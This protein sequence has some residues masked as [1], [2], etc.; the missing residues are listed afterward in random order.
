MPVCTT[1]YQA[2]ATQAEVDARP[3]S[4]FEHYTDTATTHTDGTWDNLAVDTLA[5]GQLA[6]NGDQ[7]T[8]LYAGSGVESLTATRN[9]RF[10]IGGA[11]FVS[12]GSVTYANGGSWQVEYG[13]IRVSASVIRI[14]AR[15]YTRDG[16]DLTA[17][18]LDSE[19]EFTGLTLSSPVALTI[20]G[21]AQG[22]GAASGDIV[23]I[24]G[25]MTYT[26][27]A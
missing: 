5:A 15:T 26:P 1:C 17:T 20:Q 3:I 22:T 24:L 11:T 2:P 13:I 9:I 4:L 12:T 6:H 7:V 19:G 18:V 27:A 16:A 23:M 25:S 21:R 8:A 14:W 10:Q